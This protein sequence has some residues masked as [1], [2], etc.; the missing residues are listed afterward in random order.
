MPKF[1]SRY[2][3][4]S[5]AVD[6]RNDDGS[7]VKD[8]DGKP[9]HKRLEFVNGAY[10]T[11]EPD[12]VEALRHNPSFGIT[13]LEVEEKGAKPVDEPR[14]LTAAEK[15]AAKEAAEAAAKAAAEGAPAEG[16]GSNG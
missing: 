11:E 9:Q 2:S 7:R 13:I 16:S 12:E 14:K 8:A 15:K 6:L 3:N 4:H 1:I 10:A 5:V